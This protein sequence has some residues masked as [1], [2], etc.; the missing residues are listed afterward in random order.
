MA[1]SADIKTKARFDRIISKGVNYL[2]N[3]AVSADIQT[4]VRFNRII[5][6]GQ[7]YQ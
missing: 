3:M 5:R 2:L 7:N 6:K 4:M 1:V